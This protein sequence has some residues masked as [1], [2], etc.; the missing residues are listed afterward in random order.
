MAQ[1][2]RAPLV[3]TIG[4]E[5]ADLRQEIGKITLVV[6]FQLLFAVRGTMVSTQPCS[7]FFG[8]GW[9]F[10]GTNLRLMRKTIGVAIF[11]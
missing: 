8:R 3:K 1:A 7:S 11:R 10:D 6:A 2:R 4:A 5:S 9:P